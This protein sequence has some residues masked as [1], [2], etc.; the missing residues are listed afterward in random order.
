MLTLSELKEGDVIEGAI[1]VS[2][3]SQIF[4]FKTSHPLILQVSPMLR[5]QI[6]FD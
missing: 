4:N 1:V 3:G 5:V 6:P 2:Q